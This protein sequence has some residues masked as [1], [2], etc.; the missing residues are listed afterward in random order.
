MLKNSFYFLG[1]DLKEIFLLSV[2]LLLFKT[3]NPVCAIC[4]NTENLTIHH[5]KPVV[6]NYWLK[7]DINN[8]MVLCDGCHY[9]LH[10]GG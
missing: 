5:I 7:Y 9:N 3:I 2:M 4:G 6:N 8:F 10:H 1:L